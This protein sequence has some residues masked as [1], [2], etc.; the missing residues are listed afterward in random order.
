M[1]AILLILALPNLVSLRQNSLT[2]AWAYA[3]TL[4]SLNIPKYLPEIM[5]LI[6]LRTLL[7]SASELERCTGTCSHELVRLTAKH[8][9]PLV[10]LLATPMSRM[11]TSLGV[12]A[13]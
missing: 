13:D 7:T 2:S 8:L 1:K 10:Q 4:D 12:T 5:V 3:M 11:F 6:S 9:W